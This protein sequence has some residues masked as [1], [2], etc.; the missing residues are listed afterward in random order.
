MVLSAGF[1]K[2]AEV[3]EQVVVCW[4]IAGGMTPS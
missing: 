1:E 2:S 4:L 3:L